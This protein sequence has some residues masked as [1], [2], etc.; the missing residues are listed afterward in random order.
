MLGEDGL[1]TNEV[2]YLAPNEAGEYSIVDRTQNKDSSGL[3]F[4]NFT[5]E[6]DND[7]SNFQQQEGQTIIICQDSEEH[8]NHVCI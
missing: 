5:S 8:Q 7:D 1:P 4:V 6:Y 3:E 2:V